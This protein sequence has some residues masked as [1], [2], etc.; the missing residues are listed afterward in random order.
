M[1]KD[2]R[3]MDMRRE[4]GC[5]R[6]YAWRISCTMRR[7]QKRYGTVLSESLERAISGLAYDL[8][9]IISWIRKKGLKTAFKGL[10]AALLIS[11]MVSACS[12]P[13]HG[14]Y[15]RLMSVVDI[16]ADGTV[17]L[18]TASG[19]RYDTD[20]LDGDVSLGECYSCIMDD[21]GTPDLV[22]DDV[23]VSMRYER[24]DLL[25]Q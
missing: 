11:G 4:M 25:P 2:A 18:V 1:R 14:T 6:Y 17:T 7:W 12:G 8:A 3:L 21:A 20:L 5:A 22:L 13:D 10:V 19:L 15:A 9:D 16:Y 24:P 23:I